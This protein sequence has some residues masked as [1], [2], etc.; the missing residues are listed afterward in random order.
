MRWTVRPPREGTGAAGTVATLLLWR[1]EP[2]PT[3]RDGLPWWPPRGASPA[4]QSAGCPRL[5]ILGVR[6]GGGGDARHAALVFASI[7][8]YLRWNQG[9]GTLQQVRVQTWQKE[10]GKGRWMEGL[11][12]WA[13]GFDM[14][15]DQSCV[16]VGSGDDLKSLDFERGRGRSFESLNSTFARAQLQHFW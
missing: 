10:K 5:K 16:E 6:R 13:P 2:P 1:L 9:A 11:S 3:R 14:Q 4:P 12:E 7:F 15:S 8:P